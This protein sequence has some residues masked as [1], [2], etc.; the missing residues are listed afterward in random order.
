M[1]LNTVLKWQN[2]KVRHKFYE[3]S[4][5]MT[6]CFFGHSNIPNDLKP[7]LIE[8]IEEVLREDPET[9]FYVGNHGGF[10]GLV[11][12]TLKEMKKTN[13][14]LNHRIVLAYMPGELREWE[15]QEDY[16]DT[17][18]PDGIESVPR[19]FAITARNKWMV[20][21]ADVVICYKTH[22]F[23]GAAQFIN[24]A[25]KRGKRIINLAE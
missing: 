15:R 24:M 7:K 21:I 11:A 17:I 8:K 23:G 25:A 13:P 12:R 16:M 19:K 5:I 20:G 2:G 6:C 9:D 1:V 22:D 4:D 3:V 10:D 18:Y 14:D